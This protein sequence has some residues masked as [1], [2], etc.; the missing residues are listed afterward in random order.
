MF[1]IRNRWFAPFLFAFSVI[2]P[3]VVAVAQPAVVQH[4]T[5]HPVPVPKKPGIFDQ[6]VQQVISQVATAKPNPTLT[7]SAGNATPLTG[8]AITVTVT[9]S[10]PVSNASYIFS[11]GD[12]SQPTQGSDPQQEH[13]YTR[14]GEVVASVRA[15]ATFD[16]RPVTG[17]SRVL[18][19]VG[20]APEIVPQP[21]GAVTQPSAPATVVLHISPK[22]ALPGRAIEFTASIDPPEKLEAIH[23]YFGDGS[24]ATAANGTAHTYG[25]PGSYPA[26]V[27]AEPANGAAAV[28]SAPVYVQIRSMELPTL[29]LTASAAHPVTTTEVGVSATLTPAENAVSYRFDWGDGSPLD[30]VDLLGSGH[31]TY[32]SAGN[33]SVHVTAEVV[34]NGKQ[35]P[36]IGKPIVLTVTS[37]SNP[38][39]ALLALAGLVTLASLCYFVLRPRVS[40]RY[41]STSLDVP[42]I[43]I[44]EAPHLSVSFRPGECHSQHSIS[45][46]K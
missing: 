23:Y 7:M 33:Y 3:S 27:A 29:T 5:A 28:T 26:H 8:Q 22:T 46:L 39:V 14:T 40:A 18:I 32:T 19:N 44:A 37:P 34:R 41:R 20:A 21:T 10:Q 4:E 12:G 9:W 43:S 31:H 45:F 38:A 13:V 30:S 24:D 36:V 35:L 42:G 16:E 25:S 17:A 6:F 15:T 1:R 2:A 11:W